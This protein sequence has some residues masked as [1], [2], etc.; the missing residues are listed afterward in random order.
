MRAVLLG[1]AAVQDIATDHGRLCIAMA[2]NFLDRA[3][4]IAP[5]S[6]YVADKCRPWLKRRRAAI[7]FFMAA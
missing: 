1:P 7:P 6:G 2:E 4:I 5:S 3:E